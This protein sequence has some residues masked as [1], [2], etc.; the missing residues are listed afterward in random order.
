MAAETVNSVVALPVEKV[1]LDGADILEED[2]IFAKLAQEMVAAAA[3][4]GRQEVPVDL[5]AKYMQVEAHDWHNRIRSAVL[6]L[7]SA[8]PKV[9]AAISRL[10]GR[11]WP[12]N[13]VDIWEAI[14]AEEYVRNIVQQEIFEFEL[15]QLQ[16][17]I[18]ALEMTIERYDTAAL[19]E[20]GHFLGIWITQADALF[21]RMRNSPNNIHLLL[22]IVTVELYG[23]NNTANWTQALVD[24]FERSQGRD[25]HF[26]Q[27]IDTQQQFFREF[28]KI[29]KF[30]WRT[31]RLRTWPA[32]CR[33]LLLF[34]SSYPTTFRR[35]FLL[36]T[37]SSSGGF[38]EA[39]I[40][41]I[42]HTDSGRLSNPSDPIQLA[43][44]K[45]LA[46]EF[47]RDYGRKLYGGHRHQVDVRDRP[48]QEMRMEFARDV[49]ASLQLHFK[50]GLAHGPFVKIPAPTEQPPS[51]YS[52]SNSP[53]RT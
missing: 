30:G 42:F 33:P 53:P 12:A 18:E 29:T 48:I 20:K 6:G 35:S 47:W 26:R 24:M 27:R 13:K 22:H 34:T 31:R 36:L 9:G 10:I 1:Q 17:D 52:A 4:E 23:S 25:S 43:L 39:H 41:R 32:A 3:A 44:I 7:I 16:N 19:T 38:S 8:V 21:M 46:T 45:R 51:A 11:F 28:A 40:P 50:D 15:Q 14:K 49:L 5:I 2:T 37:G